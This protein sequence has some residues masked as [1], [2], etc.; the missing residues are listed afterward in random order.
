MSFSGE[1]K[2]GL[3]LFRLQAIRFGKH[4]LQHSSTARHRGTHGPK[5]ASGEARSRYC[6]I[7][8]RHIRGYSTY[9]PPQARWRWQGDHLSDPRFIPQPWLCP[10]NRVVMADNVVHLACYGGRSARRFVQCRSARALEVPT[11]VHRIVLKGRVVP[12]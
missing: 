3:S 10:C 6:S 9:R 7:S 1:K 8:S 11:L 4:G 12:A 5:H 2:S